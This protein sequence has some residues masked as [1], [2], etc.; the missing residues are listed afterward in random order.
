LVDKIKEYT[1]E[2]LTHKMYVLQSAMIL[3]DYLIDNGNIPLALDLIKRCSVHDNSKFESLE[4][5]SLM[6]IGDKTDL[7]DPNIMLTEDKC[8]AIRIHWQNNPH[9]PEYHHTIY[10]M[11]DLDLMEMACD[12][13]ARSMQY[14]TNFLDFITTRQ[15]NRFQFPEEI[16]SKYYQFCCILDTNGRIAE[17]PKCL[18]KKIS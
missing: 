15:E 4:M 13:Y 3:S 17:T 18:N 6:S 10:G 7:K 11:S 14:G 2:C 5:K 12:C 16:F 8:D 9:H 1:D